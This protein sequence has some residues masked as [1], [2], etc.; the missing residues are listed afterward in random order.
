MI[1]FNQKTTRF[2][3][4][5]LRFKP[6]K[7]KQNSYIAK[8]SLI[9]SNTVIDNGTRINGKITIKGDGACAIKKYCAFGSDIKIITSNH[10]VSYINLQVALQNRIGVISN[11]SFKCGVEI[12]NNVWIGDNVVILPNV[13]IGNGAIVGAGSIVTKDIPAYSICAGNPA[14]VIKYRFDNETI[15]EIEKLEWWEWSEEK[16][17]ENKKIFDKQW[18]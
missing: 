14:K 8:K 18:L 12:G 7:D 10:V 15:L 2:H 13:K 9:A 11:S 4:F 17:K 5:I 3:N 1:E 16:M 6:L